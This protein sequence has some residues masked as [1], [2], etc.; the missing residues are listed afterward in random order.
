MRLVLPLN[1][2]FYAEMCDKMLLGEVSFPRSEMI[3]LCAL[4]LHSSL[5]YMSTRT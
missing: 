1:T 3:I 2:K 5:D 4:Q